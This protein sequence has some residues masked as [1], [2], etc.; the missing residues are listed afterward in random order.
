[1]GSDRRGRLLWRR[2]FGELEL[3]DGIDDLA[4]GARVTR[5]RHQ[6]G[7]ARGS[8]KGE[9][10]QLS[11]VSLGGVKEKE[12]T[13]S[14]GHDRSTESG[15]GLEAAGVGPSAQHCAKADGSG[16]RFRR[17]MKQGRKAAD[18]W[19]RKAADWWVS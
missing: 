13:V 4:G 9:L 3:G 12:A 19:E 17:T 6:L 10:G 16:R 5:V 15:E 11:D 2:C 8:G 1:V 7:E 14:K 18:W